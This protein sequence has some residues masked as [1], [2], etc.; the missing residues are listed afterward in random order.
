MGTRENFKLRRLDEA[1]RRGVMG[2]LSKQLNQV[3]RPPK[4]S[5]K[6]EPP[7]NPWLPQ[8]S[9]GFILGGSLNPKP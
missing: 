6:M 9:N 5:K 8:C 3:P 1:L 2:F 7:N 4:G